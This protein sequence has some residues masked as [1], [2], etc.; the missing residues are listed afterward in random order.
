VKTDNNISGHSVAAPASL[1]KQARRPYAPPRILSREPLE[2]M[3]ATCPP[4]I[5]RGKA[6]AGICGIVRS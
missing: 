6:G 5:G 3:A 4:G 2:A 1:P